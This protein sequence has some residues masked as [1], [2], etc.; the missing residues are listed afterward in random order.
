M[1]FISKK[2]IDEALLKLA[3]YNTFFGT[4][5]LVAKKAGLPVGQTISISLD[6]LNND[7]LVDN[8]RL[9]PKSKFFFRVFRFNNAK[10][11]WNRPDY[12]GKGLQ[13]INTRSLS[14]A[15]LHQKKTRIWGWSKDYIT[16]LSKILPQNKPLPLYHLAVWLYWG[17]AWEDNATPQDIVNKIIDDYSINNDELRYLFSSEL[18]TQVTDDQS[19]QDTPVTWQEIQAEYSL[20]PDIGPEKGGVLSYLETTGIGPLHSIVFDPGARLNILTG[21]N[22]LGKTFILEIAWWALTGIWAERPALPNPQTITGKTQ[23][24]IKFQISGETKGKTQ[25]VNYSFSENRWPAA[26]KSQTISGLV[27]YARVDGSYAVWDPASLSFD[28]S[29]NIDNTS[30]A[31][32]F[33]REDV[34]KGKSSRIEGL[35]RDWTKWQ[36]KPHKY[37]FEIFKKVLAR[38]SPPEMGPLIP[39]ESIR[40]PNDPREIPTIVHSYGDVPI[41]H[42]SA[43]VRRIIT[44]AYLIVWAWNEHKIQ[45]GYYKRKAENR[46]VVIVDELEAHLHPR[47]QRVILP[48]LL[49]ISSDLNKEMDIQLIV[50]THSPLVL[51]SGEP[52]Y[53]KSSDKLFHLE[54]T[55]SGRVEFSELPF[56]TY[57]GVDSWL[58]SEVFNLGQARSREAE[59][60]ISKA[61]KLQNQEQ[62]SPEQIKNISVQLSDYL[63]ATDKFWPRWVFFAKKYG[64][65]L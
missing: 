12:A 65:D 56:I 35:I 34:W 32:V 15:F 31:L 53:D 50:A 55:K 54:T 29:G 40:L 19:F 37:P 59:L 23:A 36:D 46:M 18:D 9:N 58:T 27:V 6:S 1:K 2:L 11:E 60:A 8:Y 63:S 44:L 22:G 14:E 51:A 10:K 57:G 39:G 4:T 61:V 21:D 45:S 42:E 26:K 16:V 47:W 33:S 38:M 20:P 48:A 7:F 62:P 24:R 64:V 17:M 3:P 49:E 25:S 43:G 5:F 52:V 41:L 28:D 13:S 30:G